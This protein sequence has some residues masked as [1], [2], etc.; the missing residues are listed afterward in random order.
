MK[1]VPWRIDADQFQQYLRALRFQYLKWDTFACGELRL[2]PESIVLSAEE[3][4]QIVDMAERLAA[5]LRKIER[6]FFDNPSILASIGIPPQVAQLIRH[7]VD[8]PLQLARYDFF[9]SSTGS[10]AVS[11][12]NEDVPGGFNEIVSTHRLLTQYHPGFEFVDR[13][14]TEFLSAVP[15]QGTVALMYATGYSEDLQ[16][17]L[18]LQKI[19]AEREQ[20]SLLCSPRHLKKA[21]R[22]FKVNGRAISAAVRFYPGE[23][24]P[25]L[26]NIGYWQN[27]VTRLP[28]L[29]PLRRLISQS[30][31]IFS[32]W[33]QAQ[34]LG[35]LTNDEIDFLRSVT[36]ET[37]RW[38]DLTPSMREDIKTGRT[39]WVLK[40]NFGR[41]GE[42]VIMGSLSSEDD[43]QKA[44]QEADK[45]AQ[46]YIAQRCFDVAPLSFSDGLQYPGIGAFLI[47][48]RFAGYYS[49][50]AATPFLTHS[51]TYVPTVIDVS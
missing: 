47:N 31:A 45:H 20:S 26:Q 38:V 40:E 51:A 25:L 30:K 1:T 23:W 28:M 11:E 15:D 35:V 36:P 19:L 24:F 5:I 41:M 33:T 43:W 46:R 4:R 8:S 42:N 37:Y 12:F 39:E 21:L 32:L 6:A 14:E 22:G 10:W 27:A 9:Q 44:M 49:R 13:F 29:N 17:M 18:I 48:G 50:V 7:E 3:H 34:R 16:H 2:R